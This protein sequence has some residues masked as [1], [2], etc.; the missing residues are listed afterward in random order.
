MSVIELVPVAEAAGF[1]AGCMVIH[2]AR[3]R[4][5]TLTALLAVVIVSIVL[6]LALVAGIRH[7][8]DPE[9]MVSAMASASTAF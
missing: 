5:D 4:A 9:A 8:G 3:D 1:T 2:W 7:S 6:L